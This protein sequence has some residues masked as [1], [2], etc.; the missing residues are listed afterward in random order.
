MTRRELLP[1]IAGFSTAGVVAQQSDRK[2]P[3][4]FQIKPKFGRIKQSVCSSVF[5]RGTPFEDQCRMAAELGFQGFDLQPPDRWPILKK[6]GLLSTMT[7]GGGGRLTDA[8]NNK[9]NHAAI[10]KTMRETIEKCAEFSSPNLITFS[11]NRRGLS[12]Q[13][14]MENCV[15]LLNKVKA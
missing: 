14:G 10:E 7:S 5:Q 12:D 9:E 6:Y 3:A 4:A 15:T 2:P 1:V 13:E 11:G 8:L